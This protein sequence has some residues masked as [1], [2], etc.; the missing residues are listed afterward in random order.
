MKHKL[1]Q[2]RKT[3]HERGPTHTHV[4][5][6]VVRPPLEVLLVVGVVDRVVELLV[7]LGQA[8]ILRNVHTLVYREEHVLEEAQPRLL[9]LLALDKH[10]GHVLD[11]DWVVFVDLLKGGVVPVP[12]LAHLVLG[13]HRSVLHLLELEGG[14]SL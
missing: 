8:R 11:V 12:A 4:D 6:V 5:A 14:W 1:D 2:L 7:D 9:H 10:R 3:Y 13:A